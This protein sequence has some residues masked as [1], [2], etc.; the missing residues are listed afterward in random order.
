MNFQSLVLVCVSVVDR[1]AG[2][3]C[4]SRTT[5]TRYVGFSLSHEFIPYEKSL[6]IMPRPPVGG[7][8]PPTS[9]GRGHY[10]MRAAEDP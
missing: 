2:S 6:I 8:I 10:E 4:T 9:S 3:L 7:G 5:L 1:H